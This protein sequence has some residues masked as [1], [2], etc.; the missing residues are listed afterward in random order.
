MNTSV[1]VPGFTDNILVDLELPCT[2]DFNVATTKYF[3]ALDSGEI[4]LCVMFSGTVFY[5]DD[6]RCAANRAGAVGS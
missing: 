4:P 6:R 2:F 1:A 3:H 5:Q